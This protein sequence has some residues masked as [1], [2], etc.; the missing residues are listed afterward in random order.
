MDVVTIGETMVVFSP[1]EQGPLR[2]AR[3]FSMKFAGAESNVAIGLS[4]LGHQVRWISQVGN[5]EFGDA[6]TAFIRGE[7][8]D[9]HYVTKDS[10]AATGV[11]FKEFRRMNDTRVYYY[12]AN[13]A[14][15]RMHTENIPAD[16]VKEAK[17]LHITGIT[18]ALS[19]S[20]RLV[21]EKA[22]EFAKE[23]GTKIVFDP[24]I[25]MKIW[26]DE[27]AARHYLKKYAALS[28]IVLPGIAEARF[29]FGE[30]TPEQLAD[31]FHE[32]GIGTVVLKLGKE[33]ALCSRI[34][35]EKTEVQGFPVEHVI[36]P[37]GAGDG[38]ASGLI[39]GLLDGLSLEESANR[40][41]AIGA[42]VTM[43]YG[44][45]EGLPLKD[46]LLTFLEQS[47]DDVTR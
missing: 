9:V 4:R 37:I 43:V 12:R 18:P 20:C 21:I 44:D 46:D 16:A 19:T 40:G 34:N 31:C 36:D 45:I 25:R 32:L 38:F 28:D 30:Q 8:V 27:K 41:N 3:S 7:G 1:D 6:M 26:Q 17:Y 47:T 10:A 13:S 22:I 11:F 5:D 29:L 14:A 2:H 23:G 24:N 15:S 42:M 39:S 33:G 35:Q